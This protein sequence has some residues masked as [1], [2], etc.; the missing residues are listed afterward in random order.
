LDRGG[1]P[2]RTYQEAIERF[3]TEYLPVLKHS[4]Q[5]R[6]WVSLKQL[7]PHFGRLYLDE[8]N[9]TRLSEYVS[10]RKRGGTNNAT[11]RRDLATMSCLFTC[12]ITWDFV[13]TN[14]VKNYGK[15]HLREAPPRT[16]YPSDAEIDRLV[17]HAS[18]PAGRIIRFLAET[19]MRQEEVCG[20]EWSQVNVLRRE[21]RLT[22]TKTSSP[23]IVPL[24]DDALG[25]IVGTAR[26][27]ISPYVFW[28]DDGERFTQFANAFRQTAK[29]AGVPFRCHDLRHR[30]ASVFLQKTGDLA[31][32]QAIL[33][34]RSIT[35]TLRYAHLLTENLHAGVAKLGTKVGTTPAD[36][37]SET[38]AES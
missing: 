35:M 9:K 34:H 38:V 22:K 28:H 37:A 33:G 1:K 19:G 13:E 36:N 7:Q 30:F 27:I 29:R 11:I 23:R 4:T 15:R 17:A 5:R 20:L 31:V 18:V 10:E 3:V 26:H 14:P 12:A 2:R 8:I 25:T 21:I 6:Y 32:L 24:S 16:T